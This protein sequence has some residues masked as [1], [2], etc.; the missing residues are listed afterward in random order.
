MSLFRDEDRKKPP[1]NKT[2]YNE[3]LEEGLSPNDARRVASAEMEGV[4]TS[5]GDNV[6]GLQ[7]Y[8]HVLEY[9]PGPEPL[10]ERTKKAIEKLRQQAE[11]EAR[12]LGFRSLKQYY[13]HL[14]LPTNDL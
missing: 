10:K 1:Y 3:L 5:D 9:P 13:E 11:K 12:Q 7:T 8:C 2:F 14:G 4:N 6:D